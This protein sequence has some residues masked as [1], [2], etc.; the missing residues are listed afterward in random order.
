MDAGPRK[1][2]AARCVP[3]QFGKTS[4]LESRSRP[5][6]IRLM[7]SRSRSRLDEIWNLDSRSRI[8]NVLLSRV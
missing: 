1:W 5:E 4:A 6:C 7:G 3:P 2:V 8:G